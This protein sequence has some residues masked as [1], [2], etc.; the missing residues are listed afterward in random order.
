MRIRGL[1]AYKE[2]T[3]FGK[4]YPMFSLTEQLMFLNNS[5]TK[6]SSKLEFANGQYSVDKSNIN[7]SEVWAQRLLQIKPYFE[8]HYNKSVFVRALLSIMEKNPSFNFDSFMRRV[9]ANPQLLKVQDDKKGY[10]K[11]IERIY[12]HDRVHRKTLP[13]STAA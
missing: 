1:E 3:E 13:F 12:N 5:G 11:M 7:I 4:K 2:L 6:H 10:A 9:R 8:E